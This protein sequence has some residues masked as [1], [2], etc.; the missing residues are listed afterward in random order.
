MVFH[1]AWDNFAAKPRLGN[2]EEIRKENYVAPRVM[3]FEIASEGLL[4]VST[5]NDW[6]DGDHI[7]DEI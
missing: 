3:P 4:C 1:I 6:E 7:I 2:M 5:L